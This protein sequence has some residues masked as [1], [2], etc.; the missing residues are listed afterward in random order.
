MRALDEVLSLLE[1]PHRLYADAPEGIKLM[2]TQAVFE[3][4]W[5]MDSDV[6]GAELSE[7]VAELLTLEASWP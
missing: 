6:A 5:I 3:R 1:D 2:L 7:P 4:L